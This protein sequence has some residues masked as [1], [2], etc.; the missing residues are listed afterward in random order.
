MACKFILEIMQRKA[1]DKKF[2]EEVPLKILAPNFVGHL[3]DKE[4]KKKKED[5]DTKITICPLQELTLHHYS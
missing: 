4:G 5:T 2:T 1:Y 3:I